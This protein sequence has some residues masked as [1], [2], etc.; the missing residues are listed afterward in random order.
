MALLPLM[1]FANTGIAYY[2][3]KNHFFM[4]KDNDD[5]KLRVNKKL[6]LAQGEAFFKTHKVVLAMQISMFVIGKF[7]DSG[8]NGWIVCSDDGANW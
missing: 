1:F 5:Q 3:K 4:N 7:S 6:I 2:L 8:K